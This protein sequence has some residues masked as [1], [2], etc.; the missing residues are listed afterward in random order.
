MW[1]LLNCQTHSI[2]NGQAQIVNKKISA[3]GGPK[4]AGHRVRGSRQ[5]R[6]ASADSTDR[7]VFL[8]GV[9]LA[10]G[11]EEWFG[12]N[13]ATQ[14]KWFVKHLFETAYDRVTWFVCDCD[15]QFR[16]LAKVIR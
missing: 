15:W 7:S 13:D 10:L 8:Q 6:T 1:P 2:L 16:T 3:L 14:K 12:T 4:K 9:G 5:P 11:V